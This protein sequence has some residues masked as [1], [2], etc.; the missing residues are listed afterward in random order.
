MPAGDPNLDPSWDWTV[1]VP[2]QGHVMYYSP[3]G[4]PIAS[5]SVQ[6]PFRKNGET[7]FV[8]DD[9]LADMYK[10]D[11]W[12]LVYRD[13]GTLSGLVFVPHSG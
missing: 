13:F 7:F 12:M 9:A 5:V 6:S 11:G 8:Y 10:E 1:T 4:G 2:G 3:P